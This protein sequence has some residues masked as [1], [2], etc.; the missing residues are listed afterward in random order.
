MSGQSAVVLLLVVLGTVVGSR[1]APRVVIVAD[2]EGEL[3]ALAAALEKRGGYEVESLAQKRVEGGFG[4][5]AAV[6]MYVHRP[7]ILA[8]EKALLDY[9]R[10]GGRLLVLHHGIASAKWKNPAWLEFVGIHMAPRKDPERPWR[11][12]PNVTHTIVNL[13]PGHYVT[14]HKVRYDREVDYVSP[15]SEKRRGRFPAL[16]LPDTEIFCNQQ[17]TD[18]DVKT[19]LL[20]YRY[21]N[22]P[23]KAEM[24]DTSGWMKPTGK[25]WLFY[26]QPGHAEHDFKNPNFVQIILNC[27]DWQPGKRG[28]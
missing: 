11:V 17:H 28:E 8:V 9:A 2:K 20:G 13:A 12:Y 3:P 22:P 23:G 1:A 16:D 6:V 7:I 5:C 15:D 24:E 21:E 10:G 18:G 25:G 19:V 26:L 27:L 4:G 14:S